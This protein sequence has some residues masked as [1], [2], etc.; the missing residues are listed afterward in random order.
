MIHYE[1][2]TVVLLKVS[3]PL[4]PAKGQALFAVFKKKAGPA[5][6]GAFLNK[7]KAFSPFTAVNHNS[8][9]RPI[10]CA[11]KVYIIRLTYFVLR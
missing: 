4:V 6:A 8:D 7:A 10:S 11:S 2:I 1:C 5:V 9:V 3:H